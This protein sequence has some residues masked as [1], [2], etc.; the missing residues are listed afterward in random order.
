MSYVFNPLQNEGFVPVV[1]ERYAPA[2]GSI[3]PVNP[4]PGHI[5]NEITKEG[6]WI[7]SWFWNPTLNRWL[8]VQEYKMEAKDVSVNNNATKGLGGHSHTVDADLF[9]IKAMYTYYPVGGGS[10]DTNSYWNFSVRFISNNE[11]TS[12]TSTQT[13]PSRDFVQAKITTPI[14]TLLVASEN[15]NLFY[16]FAHS[17]TG[18]P[19][20][21]INVFA[22]VIYRLARKQ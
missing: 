13:P 7:Q 17:P 1:E 8:S 15:N 6:E 18:S 4:K 3:S 2:Y 11:E 20:N 5:W 9:F 22:S 14:D 12:F 10:L 16:R 21:L 19:S